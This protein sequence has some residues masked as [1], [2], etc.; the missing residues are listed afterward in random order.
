M[1][2]AYFF[3]NSPCVAVN[4]YYFKLR[5]QTVR[6][7][8]YLAPNYI[9]FEEVDWESSLYSIFHL[10]VVDLEHHN[11]SRADANQEIW[12]LAEAALGGVDFLFRFE[13]LYR[14]AARMSGEI[15]LF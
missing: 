6:Y 2:S 5:L 9:E 1:D 8:Y 10:E 3:H 12:V 14:L 13:L 15:S 4:I 7:T 11:A